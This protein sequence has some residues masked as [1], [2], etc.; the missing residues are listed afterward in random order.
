MFRQ[1][2]PAG[3]EIVAGGGLAASVQN[4]DQRGR[5]LKVARH[6]RKHL[7]TARIGTKTGGFDQRAAQILRQV[8]P[9]ISE[10]GDFVYLWQAAQEFDVFDE[11]QRQLLGKGRITSPSIDSCCTAK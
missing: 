6:E 10:A 5:L 4:H 11:G 3:A 2:G 8:P 9:K 1:S 7:D